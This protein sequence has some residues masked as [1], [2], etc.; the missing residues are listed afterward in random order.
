MSKKHHEEILPTALQAYKQSMYYRDKLISEQLQSIAKQIKEAINEGMT[1]VCL[2]QDK[3]Y[4]DVLF[5]LQENNYVV[6][7][8]VRDNAIVVRWDTILDQYGI[9]IV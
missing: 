2:I 9:N 7:F 6:D 3:L 8:N 5:K 4:C 1:Q